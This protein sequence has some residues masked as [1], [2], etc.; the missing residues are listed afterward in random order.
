MYKNLSVVGYWLAAWMS[1]PE[2]IAEATAELMQLL[3]RG[4]LQIAI[5]KT[6]PWQRQQRHTVPSRNAGPQGK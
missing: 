4:T 5:G 1:R 6:F 3:A 2:R